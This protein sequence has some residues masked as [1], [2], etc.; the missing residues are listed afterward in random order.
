MIG[1]DPIDHLITCRARLRRSQ[2][3]LAAV[4]RAN[5]HRCV[6]A[7]S[8]AYVK[9]RLNELW[10]AQLHAAADLIVTLG[11]D[12]RVSGRSIFPKVRR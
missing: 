2:A 4:R 11:I 5:A 6:L 12:I 7:D 9:T 1:D 3:H 8:E 10:N